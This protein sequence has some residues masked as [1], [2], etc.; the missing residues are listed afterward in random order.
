MEK[1]GWS[2]DAASLRKWAFEMKEPPSDVRPP[3]WLPGD[4]EEEYL[5]K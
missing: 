4:D 5:K 1:G 2:V 3:A